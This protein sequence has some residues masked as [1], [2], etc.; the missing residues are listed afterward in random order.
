M[1]DT[2]RQHWLVSTLIV[3]SGM[4]AVL[5]NL[6]GASTFPQELTALVQSPWVLGIGGGGVLLGVSWMVND[7][8]VNGWKR[9]SRD[10]PSTP[11]TR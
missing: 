2:R 6:V 7:V 1:N 4:A 5:A 8:R 9:A 10:G 11:T 3:V